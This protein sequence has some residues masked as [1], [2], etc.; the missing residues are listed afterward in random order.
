MFP[1]FVKKADQ[2]LGSLLRRHFLGGGIILAFAG[3]P[4]ARAQTLLATRTK[5]LN[6]TQHLPLG[7]VVCVG[8]NNKISLIV[9]NIEMGQG[10]YTTEAI[11]IAEELEIDPEAVE[12]LTALPQDV[13][14]FSPNFLKSLSTGG[15]RSVRKGWIPLRQAGATARLMLLAAAAARWNVSQHMLKAENGHIK[16]LNGQR[17]IQYGELVTEASQ[18][19]IPQTVPL[20]SPDQWKLI[21]RT[22]PRVDT[23]AKTK[24]TAVFGIDVKIPGMVIGA[25]MG[26]P[27]LG[28][29]IEKIDDI[30]CKKIP[31]IIDVLKTKDHISVL[32]KNYWIAQKGLKALVVKWNY[33]EKKSIS[34]IDIRKSIQDASLN[35]PTISAKN[36][37]R[38]DTHIER[39]KKL[40]AAY[41]LPFLSHTPMEPANVTIHARPDS[42]DVWMGTQVPTKARTA[43]SN[44]MGLPEEKVSIYNHMIGGS[45]GRRLATD[46]LECAAQFAKQTSRPV[47]FI[48]S[49]EEDIRQDVFRPAY[50]DRIS[51]TLGQN[52]LPISWE[53][54]VSGPSVVDRMAPGGL[55]AGKLDSDAVAG[56]IDTPYDFPQINITWTRVN[57]PVSVGWWRGVGP[58]HNVFV[59]ESFID[60]LAEATHSDP[61]E[62]RLRLLRN[63][64]RSMNVLRHLAEVSKWNEP[65]PAGLGRG[66][67]LHNAF[68]THCAIVVESFI[69]DDKSIFI[70]K[71]TAVVDCGVVINQDGLK[72]QM[73][74]GIIFGLSAALYEEITFKNGRIEQSNFNDYRL[75][76]IHEAP[77]IDVHIIKSLESPGGIGE[78]GTTAAFPALG[79][80]IAHATGIRYR[81]Y[82]F[83]QHLS[84]KI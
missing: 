10:I 84:P 52:G 2:A 19:N 65:L 4:S 24:G 77:Q 73:E 12:V 42:C 76:R 47:K 8:D 59:V 14:I 33:D 11:M 7:G 74:G 34:S 36:T 18:Q 82:P 70:K 80:A 55:P 78:V 44:I 68:G 83:S 69:K 3:L 29:T 6:L 15:S 49:R 30:I 21:G 46:F 25:V 63:N 54:H 13:N 1:L 20:K 66:L 71:V 16:D 35:T 39:S 62:Y 28:A 5:D 43:V 27:A 48:W 17:C 37:H 58:A 38:E 23:P 61:L 64:P 67:A 60:E 79:N 75:M 51:A 9:P 32:A 31:G 53:H 57:L 41:E 56:A 81:R 50:Y 72:A 22:F 45:Y 40:E 26:P